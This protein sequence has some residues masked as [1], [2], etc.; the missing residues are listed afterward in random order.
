MLAIT[1]L[2]PGSAFLG[3]EGGGELGD[4]PTW[5]VDPVDGTTN[6]VHGYPVAAV[7]VARWSEGEVG[8]A[9]VRDLFRGLSVTAIRGEGIRCSTDDTVFEVS[10]V[11]DLSAALIGIGLPYDR[12]EADEMF[13]V[14]REI[15]ERCQDLRR[16]GSAILDI[17]DVA[18]GRL[19]AHVEIDLRPWDVMATGLILEEAGGRLTD[20]GGGGIVW[21]GAS[22]TKRVIASNGLLHDQISGITSPA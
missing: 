18:L 7:G 20:W 9:A 4:G 11:D 22:D 15:F 16:G 21:T 8:L 17:L 6:V 19:D 2:L 10:R 13:G 12:S 14:A 3:E 1:R 5:V